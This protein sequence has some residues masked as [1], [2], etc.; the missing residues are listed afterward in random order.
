MIPLDDRGLLLGDGL[1]ETLACLDGE[2]LAFA[3]H[4]ARLRAGALALGLPA[5]EASECLAGLRKAASGRSG[6]LALRLTYTAGSSGR[7]L[8]RD[9]AARPR[10]FAVAAPAPA[11]SAAPLSLVLTD[12][13]RA[14]GAV[15]SRFKTLS[16]VDNVVARQRAR[17][18]GADE[19]VL[20]DGQGRVSCCAAANL[21][22][23]EGD[24]L[25]TPSAACGA[26]PGVARA[27]TLRIA[28][29][30]GLEA[31]EAERGPGD[32]I[33]ASGVFVTNSL[34]G[35]APVGRIGDRATREHPR[36]LDLVERVRIRSWRPSP[37]AG[38]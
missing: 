16:Y 19:G 15:S 24:R 31:L 7:G 2:P 13:V 21:F 35:A 22:W 5:P 25:V 14:A 27:L 17:A 33:A 3:A 34:L 10:L 4:F 32:L 1:F 12:Q 11:L 36:L 29:D 9:P 8:D 37:T 28:R 20:L 30:L 26:L 6:R 18:A 23:F 38:A